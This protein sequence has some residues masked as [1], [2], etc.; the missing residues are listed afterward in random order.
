MFPVIYNNL[1]LI[2]L[3][4]WIDPSAEVK[5]DENLLMKIKFFSY[6]AFLMI[7]SF[8]GKTQKEI[9]NQEENE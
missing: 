4:I 7:S 8:L 2:G 1:D 6:I 9:D 3:R 5:E